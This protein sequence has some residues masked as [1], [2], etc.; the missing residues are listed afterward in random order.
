MFFAKYNGTSWSN[1][2]SPGNSAAN[3]LDIEVKGNNYYMAYSSVRAGNMYVFV[4]QY[5][6]TSW[7]QLG[8]SLLLGNSGSGGWFDFILDNNE[9]PTLL[10]PVNAVLLA[11]KQMVQFTGGSWNTIY[12]FPGS[13]PTI[14]RE[15][16]GIFDAQNKLIC[17]TQGYVSVPTVTYFTVTHEI[18]GGTQTTVGDTIFGPSSAHR[19]KLAG[20]STYLLF[21][22]SI[23]TEVLAYKLNGNVWNFV[24]DTVGAN[25]GTMLSADVASSG[26]I[27][28][29]TSTG[30]LDR[31]LYLYDTGSRLEMD[32]VNLSGTLLS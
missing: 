23:Q 8:D 26:K 4:K 14:F 25:I 7:T 30:N 22:Q 11:D 1:L 16:A 27:V 6:G 28:F 3:Y 10:G 19:V 32:S 2:P 29:N 21:N 24:A 13:A 9:V 20:N 18:N 15:N 12:T 31:S 5:N 17:A